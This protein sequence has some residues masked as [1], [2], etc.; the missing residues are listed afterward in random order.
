MR[1]RIDPIK[2]RKAALAVY[3]GIIGILLEIALVAVFI[4]AGFI[5]TVL[6]WRALG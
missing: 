1:I 5:L 3:N 2:S 4:L 6:C